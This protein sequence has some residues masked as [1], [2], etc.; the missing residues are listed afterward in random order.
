[1]DYPETAC[2]KRKF[3]RY[4]MGWIFA[5]SL[6]FSVSIA[7][8]KLPAETNKGRGR[9]AHTVAANAT[10]S[11]DAIWD[12]DLPDTS[13][14]SAPIFVPKGEPEVLPYDEVIHEAAGRY[15]VDVDLIM[16]V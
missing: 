2:P 3:I 11:T 7:D 8:V 13:D 14:H 6:G 15:D 12:H 10:L 5:L 16:A 9:L 1:M 4:S